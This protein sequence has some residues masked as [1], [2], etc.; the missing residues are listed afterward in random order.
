[1]LECVLRLRC[2]ERVS[3]AEAVTRGPSRPAIRAFWASPSAAD[4]RTSNTACTRDAVTLACWPPGPDERDARTRI[5]DSGT[6]TPARISSRSFMA[7]GTF[8]HPSQQTPV[9]RARALVAATCR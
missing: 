3:W 1:M 5:S 6:A 9:A 2:W 7:P 8:P 4:A